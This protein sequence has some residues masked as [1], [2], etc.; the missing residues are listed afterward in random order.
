M[1]F[2]LDEHIELATVEFLRL[3]RHNVFHAVLDGGHMRRGDNFHFAEARHQNRILVTRDRDFD[4]N[5]EFPLRNHP[6]VIIVEPGVPPGAELVNAVLT[7]L[8]RTFH[9][10][11]SLL[12]SKVIAS[13][14][15]YVLITRKDRRHSSW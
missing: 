13:V 1:R 4:N 3:R 14:H 7:E 5:R 9:T 6:G 8:L 10:N 11:R 15:G 2:Y 12:E